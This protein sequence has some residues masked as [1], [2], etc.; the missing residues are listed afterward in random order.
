MRPLADLQRALFRAIAGAHDDAGTT[1]A[2]FAVLGE[3]RGDERLSPRGRL[4]VYASMYCARLIDA[5]RE[6]YP[7]V[8][9]LLGP[10]RFGEVA[11]AYVAAHP[12]T[13][14]SLRWF[15]EHFAA[16]LARDGSAELPP[17][18]ADLARL[19]WA[20]LAVFDAPDAPMLDLDALRRLP[21][22]A[23]TTLRLRLVPALE[24]IDVAWPVHRIWAAIEAGAPF[25][26]T[27]VGEVHLR[28]WRQRD[29]VFQAAMDEA[30]R[31]ALA[32]VAA[33]ETFGALCERVATV[34][35]PEESAAMAGSLVLRWIEDGILAALP[36]A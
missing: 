17:Y 1:A 35:K 14:P 13:H 26:A 22:D 11:H 20:R 12:S 10:E 36:T 25:D 34:T 21:P 4:D 15:G 5:L 28:V 8:A 6:D 27:G 33:G 2:G 3:I 23:W 31:I 19:E 7:R 24:L 18:V 30:E 32:T 16:F 29:G 9:A